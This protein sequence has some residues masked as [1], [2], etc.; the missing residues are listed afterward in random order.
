MIIPLSVLNFY[1]SL[2]FNLLH[3]YL[4]VEE[5]LQVQTFSVRMYMSSQ[6][7]KV[8]PLFTVS[9]CVEAK[10]RLEAKNEWSRKNASDSTASYVVRALG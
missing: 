1:F 10:S 6:L 3:L 7:F 4:F 2:P 9:S 8:S 5:D